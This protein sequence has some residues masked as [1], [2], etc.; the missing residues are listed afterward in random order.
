MTLDDL[1]HEIRN[2][3][4]GIK[5]ATK[6]CEKNCPQVFHNVEVRIEIKHHA[7]RIERALKVYEADKRLQHFESSSNID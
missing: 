6:H 5:L 7:N 1:V 3:L 4:Q 2:G